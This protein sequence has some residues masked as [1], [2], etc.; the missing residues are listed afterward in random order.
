MLTFMSAFLG[1][2]AG[3]FKSEIEEVGPRMVYMGTGTVMKE[4]VG[5]RGA[6]RV[7]VDEADVLRLRSLREADAVSPDTSEWN[8]IVRHGART[9][10]LVV[11]GWNAEG[12][13]MRNF[14]IASGRSF[15][16]LDVERAARVAVRANPSA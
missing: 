16:P 11:M 8:A 15:S 7:E 13:S 3:H 6:R 1:G 9:K 2:M 12:L 4:R 5:A 14:R 10:L